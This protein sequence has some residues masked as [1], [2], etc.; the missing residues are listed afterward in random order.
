MYKHVS[1]GV[2]GVLFRFQQYFSHIMVTAIT[3][4]VFPGFTSTGLGLC[5]ILPNDTHAKNP[6]DPVCLKPK[7]YI[8]V[9]EPKTHIEIWEV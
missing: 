3:I 9:T 2:N 4:D 5:S 7:K 6:E 8:F 1:P